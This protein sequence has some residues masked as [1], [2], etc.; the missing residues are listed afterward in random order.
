MTISIKNPH[1]I[2]E[3][4]MVE[5]LQAEIWGSHAD[6][7]PVHMLITFAKEGGIVQLMC[8]NDRPIGFSFGFLSRTVDGQLKLASHQAGLLPA[9]RS[10]GLGRQLK[11]AQREAALVAGLQL[12]TW[13]FDP[14]QTRNGRL[15]LHKLGGVCNTYLLNLYGDM[16]DLLNQGVPSDRFRVDWWLESDHVLARLQGECPEPDWAQVPVLNPAQPTGDWL[17]PAAEV[18]WPASAPAC[19]VEA[20]PNIPQLMAESPQLALAWRMHLRHIF[21]TLFQQGYVAVDLVRRQD[22]NYYLLQH[23]WPFGN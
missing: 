20:P 11:L 19:L 12:I 22:R 21:E 10:Q 18:A 23:N 17:Q 8:D 5:Q 4:C 7:V 3:F 6:A 13:T 15:N 2:A 9:Y 14:L 16:D 1:T